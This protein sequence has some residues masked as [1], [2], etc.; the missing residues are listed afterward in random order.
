MSLSG[1]TRTERSASIIGG[2]LSMS[3]PVAVVS[4]ATCARLRQSTKCKPMSRL[5]AAVRRARVAQAMA[6]E[7]ELVAR[8]IVNQQRRQLA[9][10]GTHDD[11]VKTVAVDVSQC[12]DRRDRRA[13]DLLCW[14]SRLLKSPPPLLRPQHRRWRKRAWGCG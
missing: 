2:S 11:G 1:P 14:R 9:D 7:R 10:R 8:D 4:R 6:A 13:Q 3:G 5:S 12:A